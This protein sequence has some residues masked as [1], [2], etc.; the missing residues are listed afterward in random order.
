MKKKEKAKDFVKT[1]GK[2]TMAGVMNPY[3]KKQ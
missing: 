1:N 2:T 3:E